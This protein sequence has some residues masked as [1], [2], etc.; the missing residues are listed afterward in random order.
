MGVGIVILSSDG[1]RLSETITAASRLGKQSLDIVAQAD[2]LQDARRAIGE[3]L[4]DVVLIDASASVEDIPKAC[5]QIAQNHPNTKI[6]VLAIGRDDRMLIR[7]LSGGASGFL[8]KQPTPA[9]IHDC[10]RTIARNRIH[11]GPLRSNEKPAPGSGLSGHSSAIDVLSE[12]EI[13]VLTLLADGAK[14]REIA[15]SLHISEKTVETHR[16]H[17]MQ[18]LDLHSIAELTKFA[19]KYGLTS[20]DDQ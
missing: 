20:L 8:R 5:L 7:A 15:A 17:I 14:T 12:R 18:K 19:V 9:E 16:G 4:P 2:N 10:M 1:E 11:I 6:V 13:E 3:F